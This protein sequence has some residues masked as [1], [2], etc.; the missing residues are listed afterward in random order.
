MT[1]RP[2][3]EEH[4]RVGMIDSLVCS[5]PEPTKYL[6]PEDGDKM[7]ALYALITMKLTSS[8]KSVAGALIWHANSS[9]GRCDPG[10][11]TLARETGLSRR[12]VIKAVDELVAAGILTRQR[13]SGPKGNATTA[14]H[15]Q[16]DR[17]RAAF[18]QFEES[19]RNRGGT[20]VH[21][22]S[23][24][25]CTHLVN[26]SAP[27]PINRTHEVNP[28]PERV[29]R[30]SD[31]APHS[32]EEEGL[33]E[34]KVVPLSENPKARQREIAYRTPRAAAADKK[35]TSE[36]DAVMA[37]LKSGETPNLAAFF[38]AGEEWAKQSERLNA[39]L[40]ADFDA[41]QAH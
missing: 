31:D 16:W 8:A 40:L 10:L 41:K 22:P 13:R 39:V 14:Y 7:A 2:D 4:E 20:P 21:L 18:D 26:Y 5:R 29:H 19:V 30:P 11:S 38:A 24:P 23:E 28:C 6:K 37:A 25:Q 36:F 33:Q 34:G 32:K 12:G 27:E 15:L 1:K 3:M 9:H 35:L 17:L